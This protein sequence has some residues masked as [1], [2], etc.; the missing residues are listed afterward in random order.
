MKRKVTI[1]FVAFY[2]LNISVILAHDTNTHVNEYYQPDPVVNP[3][4]TVKSLEG[5]FR[6]N[7]V[8]TSPVP[9]IWTKGHV[10]VVKRN[11]DGSNTTIKEMDAEVGGLNVKDQT[12]DD[13][14]NGNALHY[15][16][17]GQ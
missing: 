10:K 15:N 4:G 11:D 16:T 5:D 17:F 9:A 3:Y 8:N 14:V 7:N 6:E 13:A 1:F 2:L 12:W